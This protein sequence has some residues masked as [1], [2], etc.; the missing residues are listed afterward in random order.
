MKNDFAQTT[1]L[2][3]GPASMTDI[4]R[5]RLS[6]RLALLLPLAATGCQTIRDVFVDTPK[7]PIPG[8][9]V[10]VLPPSRGVMVD[11]P[12]GVKIRLPPP[13]VRADW[14]QP[15]GGPTHEIG[16]AQVADQLQEAWSANV[17]EDAGYRRKIP[18]TPVVSEGRVVTMDPDGLVRAFD[19]QSGNRIW[20]FDTTPDDN[21]SSNVGGGVSAAPGV[22]YAA[23]GR[24][25]LIALEAATGKPT[26]R[27]PLPQP[28][29]AAP[30]VADGRLFVALLGDILLAFDA[31]T[32]NRIWSYQGSQAETGMLGLPAPAY[33]DGLLVAGFASGELV[34]LRAA[35][36]A[37]VWLDNLGAAHGGEHDLSAIRGLPVIQDGR[38]YAISLGGLM[39]S[40]DLPSGR[41]LWEREISSNN[42]P[43]IAGGFIF[44]LTS[45]S[46]LVAMDR[47]DGSIIWITQLDKWEDV[48]KQRDPIFWT[49]PVLAGDRL[50]VVSGESVAQAVSP[51]T[52]QVLG[53]QKLSGPA[54]VSPVVA[55]GTLLVITD[56][57][58]LQAF[59]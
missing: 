16:H 42:T 26:W 46:Q 34:T 24:A 15:G 11:N 27:I 47:S 40:N 2:T 5:I 35:T 50:V 10:D 56:D 25:E 52:G 49:G 53:Q 6:R 28:A 41:R 58:K 12:R 21:E 51:Y 44:V 39:V 55:G 1:Q 30:T 19:L 32:G 36:G 18:S 14:P 13:T 37:V 7:P 4:T 45:D 33:A 3:T 57:A 9:R 29:R 54:A 8:T 20:E 23:T 59:R 43:C 17:G 31:K 22:V 38:V 48:E